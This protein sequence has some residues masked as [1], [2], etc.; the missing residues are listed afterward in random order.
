MKNMNSWQRCTAALNF[1][2]PD[3]IP[4]VPQSFLVAC[5]TAGY[6]IG[7]I[8]KSGKLIAKT[9]LIALERFGYDGIVVDVDDASLAEA[10]GAKVLFREDDVAVVDDSEPVLKHIR[11]VQDLRVPDP[12]KDG[13]LPEWLEATRI[14]REQLK[15]EV[16]LM[17]RADQGPFDLACLLRGAQNFLMDLL[18]E[19]P[20][21]IWT[22]L[23][24]CRKAS[25]AFAKAQKDCGADATSIGEAYA[26]PN[27]IS[28][29]MYRTFAF[30]HQ[31]TM[32]KEVQEYGI[33]L[34]LH[35]CGNASE[36]IEDMAQTGARIIEIDWKVDMARA[37]SIIGER[38][39]IMGNVD[40]SDPLVWGTPEQVI[41][42]SASVIRDTGGLG[43]F[44]SSGCAM[45]FNTPDANVSAMV[46]AAAEYGTEEQILELQEKRKHEKTA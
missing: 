38:A 21:D 23:D 20:E 24:F 14:L 25:T 39:V 29:E 37:K 13:R 45:G 43:V 35:I 40:P 22:L 10:C 7:Q 12:F 30:D 17:G 41:E 15:N 19:K 3:R 34:S 33:P 44:L 6:Q 36:I 4:V 16:F 27:L 2:V 32:A 46:K 8:N 18:T 1:Q 9:H 5:R 42:K 31:R 28:P 11:D 26:G